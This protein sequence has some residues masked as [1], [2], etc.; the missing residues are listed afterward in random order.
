[1]SRRIPSASIALAVL[2]A[3]GLA[4]PASA[5]DAPAEAGWTVEQAV[6]WLTTHVPPAQMTIGIL[7]GL[8]MGELLRLAWRTLEWVLFAVVVF[9]KVI[10]RYGALAAIAGCI[11][12]FI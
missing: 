11:L 4:M 8:A 5:A 9:V 6:T 2:L 3:I 1:M 7:I 10:A 12:Y